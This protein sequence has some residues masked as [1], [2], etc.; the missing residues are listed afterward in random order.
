MAKISE[1]QKLAV[2]R[3]A[4][5]RG[6]NLQAS[7]YC[8][9]NAEVDAVYECTLITKHNRLL[10]LKAVDEAP[11][12]VEYNRKQLEGITGDHETV[13]AM[14]KL[15]PVTSDVQTVKNEINDLCRKELAETGSIGK[16]RINKMIAGLRSTLTDE[17]EEFER[18][19][20]YTAEY[21][22]FLKDLGML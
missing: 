19:H 17:E 22:Q 9:T 7:E 8:Q 5:Q 12:N 16:K 3:Y 15:Y 14:Q 11:H 4:V 10:Y 2:A 6:A 13:S 20:K 21:I 18:S 1:E